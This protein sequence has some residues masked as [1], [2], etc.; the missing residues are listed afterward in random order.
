MQKPPYE[1]TSKILKLITSI[2]EK[3]GEIN[4]NYINKPS[5][6][7]RKQNKIKTIHSSLKIEGNTLSEAQIT[8]LL[9]NKK[10]IG[11][12]KDVTEVLNAISVYENLN[13]YKPNSEVSFLKAHKMLMKGLV[14]KPG[15]YRTESVGIS[16]NNKVEQINHKHLYCI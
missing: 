1:I 2:S 11:P 13:N 3:I 5:P 10:V 8:A 14:Q 9:E 16:K 7:L 6:T 15:T 12:K 4:A